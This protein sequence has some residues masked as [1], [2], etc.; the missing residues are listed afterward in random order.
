MEKGVLEGNL[1]DLR[2][3]DSNIVRIFTCSAF[4]DMLP[5]RNYLMKNTYPQLRDICSELG[6][7][8]EVVDLTWSASEETCADN[9]ITELSWKEISN[10]QRL[11]HGPNFITLLGDKHGWRY[12]PSTITEEEFEILVKI[13]KDEGKDVTFLQTWFEKDNNIIPPTYVLQRTSVSSF[14]Y[15]D[16][17]TTSKQSDIRK[18]WL[19]K[20]EEISQ[21][22]RDGV[23]NAV[24]KKV[25]PAQTCDKYLMSVTEH[26][27]QKGL[28]DSLDP[29]K[30]CSCFVRVL[31]DV[32]QAVDDV[33]IKLYFDN[34]NDKTA[35]VEKQRHN[36]LKFEMIPKVLDKITL[37]NFEV[38]WKSG[39]M[40]PTFSEHKKYLQQLGTSVK[41][42]LLNQIHEYSDKRLQDGAVN[43]SQLI[44][45][46]LHHNS[47]CFKTCKSFYGREK[48]LDNLKFALGSKIKIA[49]QDVFVLYGACGSGKTSVSAMLVKHARVWFN[50]PNMVVISRFLGT[51]QQSNNI[52]ELISS[53]CDHISELYNLEK[54]RSDILYDVN[55]MMQH[56]HYLVQQ[57]KS[58]RLLIVLDSIDQLSAEDNAYSLTWL[59]ENLNENVSIVVS[60]HS[61]RA[62]I[63]NILKTRYTFPDNFLPIEALNETDVSTILDNLFADRKRTLT[64]EQRNYLFECCTT[65]PNP[66]YLRL[67]FDKASKWKS[68]DSIT[69]ISLPTTLNSAILSLFQETE[70]KFG[71]VVVSHA[72][73]YITAS[74]NGLTENEL[75]D[76][77]SLDNTVLNSV[78][79]EHSPPTEEFIRFPS[80]F[81]KVIRYYLESHLLEK[82]SAGCTVLN[83]SHRRLREAAVDRYLSDETKTKQL[84]NILA[85]FFLGKYSNASGKTVCFK[86]S[87]KVLKDVDRLVKTQPLTFQKCLYNFRKLNEMP[88]ALIKSGRQ[89]E[90]FKYVFFNFQWIECKIKALSVKHLVNDMIFYLELNDDREVKVVHDAFLLRLN[91]I[92]KEKDQIASQLLGTL[93][94]FED[95]GMEN[96]KKLLT[97]CR[98]HIH[99]LN[100]AA[101][102]LRSACMIPPGGTLR[103]TLHGHQGNVEKVLFLADIDNIICSCKGKERFIYVY[104]WSIRAACNLKILKFPCNGYA[105]LIWK[106]GWEYLLII[107]DQ[108]SYVDIRSRSVTQSVKNPNA[109]ISCLKEKQD[110]ELVALAHTNGH[111]R[112]LDV[113]LRKVTAECEDLK[114][115]CCMEFLSNSTEVAIASETLATLALLN[116]NNHQVRHFEAPQNKSKMASMLLSMANDS[117]LISTS[118]DIINVWD[119]INLSFSYSLED[120][121]DKILCVEKVNEDVFASGS[122]DNT[123]KIWSVGH[124]TLLKNMTGHENAV[125]CLKFCSTSK[126]LISGSR[127]DYV[128]I[129]NL[130]TSLC[131]HTLIGHCSWISSVDVSYNGSIVASGSSDG[132]VKLWNTKLGKEQIKQPKFVHHQKLCNGAVISNNGYYAATISGKEKLIVWNESKTIALR[133]IES[134]PA[135]VA[136][137]NENSK[138]VIGTGEGFVNVYDITDEAFYLCFSHKSHYKSVVG[139]T[140]LD[141]TKTVVSVGEDGNVTLCDLHFQEELQRLECH[142]SNISS[143]CLSQETGLLATGGG[144]NVV[145][146]CRI[147]N[148]E[149]VIKMKL[150]GHEK[151]ISCV[152]TS[153]CNNYL[154]S[155][156]GAGFIFVWKLSDGEN[157]LKIRSA[158]DSVTEIISL[159][160]NKFISAS[161]DILRQLKRWDVSSEEAVTEYEGHANAVLCVK[162]TEDNKYMLSSSR[163]GTIKLWDIASGDLLDSIDFHS[164]IKHLDI[165]SLCED[166]FY[167]L[168]AVTKTGSVAFM[169]LLLPEEEQSSRM[170]GTLI[171]MNKNNLLDNTD[172]LIPVRTK[173]CCCAII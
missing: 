128:K 172:N 131:E 103:T 54:P 142:S 96:V 46:V 75:E 98:R 50:D 159:Q 65:C 42:I 62:N 33:T 48:L 104:F 79:V 161:L 164:P 27:V 153:V 45:E 5:E 116:Y 158:H 146:V 24:E 117:V 155:G 60:T 171:L 35:S 14:N 112:M 22:L 123:I 15:M 110:G 73:G 138:L 43:Q 141:K 124:Q 109:P 157:I 130:E 83:W 72:L 162:C 163:D 89:R 151:M 39:G 97:A 56:F 101:L 18:I 134:D 165:S 108:I 11:S 61:D 167:K 64:V 76:I 71:E 10:C 137:A 66:L 144:D 132:K 25:L 115:I 166:Y 125:G 173:K 4:T 26:E 147:N 86:Q 100:K 82:K 152:T 95:R 114:D 28:F 169:R 106:K 118:D 55:M 139:V 145:T 156:D 143:F 40:D 149:I 58:P 36:N 91:H 8:F 129:W 88:S 122:K 111:V 2:N 170:N 105:D 150:E 92:E 119:V 47:F 30:H 80:L 19:D 7:E 168:V 51:S 87:Q 13:L 9:E 93:I 21:T 77:L 44:T 84:Y 3:E 52:S 32:P 23:Q 49:E 63:L 94:G 120:H 34:I 17:Q 148:E 74:K 16:N 6:L 78:F 107:A 70:A 127:D 57:I 67:V 85:D 68:F 31:Q 1:S 160:D 12:L 90:L 29:I 102:L 121:Q 133:E 126:R 135:C 113:K 53:L 20:F 81:W 69:S 41:S 37:E 99:D 140:L 136:F 38:K 59:P 154:L